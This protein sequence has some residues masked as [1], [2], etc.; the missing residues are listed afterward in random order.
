MGAFILLPLGL[1]GVYLSVQESGAERLTFWALITSCTGAGRTLPFFGA[2]AFSLQVIGR[3]AI[4]RNDPSRL[5][6]VNSVRFGIGIGLIVT[7]FIMIAVATII[8]A[9][10]VWKSRILSKWSGIPSALGYV[11]YMPLL[12]GSPRFQSARIAGRH[13]S[14]TLFDWRIIANAFI[15][16]PILPIFRLVPTTF[17]YE[18]PPLICLYRQRRSR[19]RN[20]PNPPRINIHHND[21]QRSHRGLRLQLNPLIER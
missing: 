19:H 18:K 9:S 3:A 7:G 11:L 20:A 1:L 2:E 16:M 6:M 15:E 14:I 17:L 10:A 13:S 4:D 12:Q 5:Q 21:A 8:L